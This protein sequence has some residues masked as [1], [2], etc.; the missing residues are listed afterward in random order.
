MEDLE[1]DIESTV[2]DFMDEYMELLIEQKKI[3]DRIKI[4]CQ[5][6]NET[7]LP[8]K[9]VIKSFNQYKKQRKENPERIKQLE[10]YLNIMN[11]NSKIKEKLDILES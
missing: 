7:G 3:K 2:D 1:I 11:N 5:Q 6:F 10:D 4:L 9:Y 8:T